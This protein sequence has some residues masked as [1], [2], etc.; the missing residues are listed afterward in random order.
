MPLASVIHILIFPKSHCSARNVNIA[1]KQSDVSHVLPQPNGKGMWRQRIEKAGISQRLPEKR[2]RDRLLAPGRIFASHDSLCASYKA[3]IKGTET[4]ASFR[5][6]SICDIRRTG[7][8]ASFL[9]RALS[10]C[11]L[12]AHITAADQKSSLKGFSPFS[13]RPLF[14][15]VK[16]PARGVWAS[17]RRADECHH[18]D[19]RPRK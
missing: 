9:V 18:H 13:V 7:L 14:Q 5:A 8:A 15:A 10:N 2:L 16:M 4:A 19:D 3:A 1:L 6:L 11:V 12:R 17:R